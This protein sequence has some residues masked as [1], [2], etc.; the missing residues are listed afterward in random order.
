MARVE[1]RTFIS[2]TNQIDT[3]PTPKNGFKQ[4]G[5]EFNLENLK[6]TQL[7]NW[8]APENY[9]KEIKKRFPG[10]MKGRT[11]YVIPFR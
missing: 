6:C 5:P 3:V 8:M 7:G 9:E 11:M 10:C 4:I 1:S 2:T